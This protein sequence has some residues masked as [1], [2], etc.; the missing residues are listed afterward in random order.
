M[1]L[2]AAI[3]A[4]LTRRPAPVAAAA[5]SSSGAAARSR[6]SFAIVSDRLGLSPYMLEALRQD[7]ARTVSRYAD[8]DEGSLELKLDASRANPALVAVIPLVSL[9][10]QWQPPAGLGV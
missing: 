6:L 5:D 1:G 7:I 3:R 2:L 4:A 10:E 8:V 9:K